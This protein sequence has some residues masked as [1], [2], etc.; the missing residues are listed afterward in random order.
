MRAFGIFVAVALVS[1]ST[2][3]T[4]F[5]KSK[6]KNIFSNPNASEEQR[7]IDS[8]DCDTKAQDTKSELRVRYY[9]ASKGGLSSKAG[10]A[11]GAGVAQGYL[12]RKEEFKII[13]FCLIELGYKKSW[14]TSEEMTHYKSLKKKQRWPYL[15]ELSMQERPAETLIDPNPKKKKK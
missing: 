3:E 6:A 7:K 2:P 4:A 8:A 14:L 15:L 11:F 12:G 10:A 1:M 9:T 5:A 13:E